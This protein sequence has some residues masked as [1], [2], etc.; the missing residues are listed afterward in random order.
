MIPSD[1][2][3]CQKWKKNQRNCLLLHHPTLRDAIYQNNS[4]CVGKTNKKWVILHA[5]GRDVLPQSWAFRIHLKKFL[6]WGD[7]AWDD[8][9]QRALQVL[10]TSSANH[11]AWTLDTENNRSLGICWTELESHFQM[12]WTHAGF[13]A[14]LSSRVPLH[15]GTLITS[16][17]QRGGD[18]PMRWCILNARHKIWDMV[19]SQCILAILL[20]NIISSIKPIGLC[21]PQER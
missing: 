9:L 18:G 2:E 3:L 11:S 5:D 20:L 1:F 8:I 7:G 16:T 10:V 14:S 21:K 12:V 4:I 13:S 15:K 17:F 19:T 6:V